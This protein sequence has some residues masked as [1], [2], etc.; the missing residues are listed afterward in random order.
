MVIRKK[1]TSRKILNMETSELFK[2]MNLARQ[3]GSLM[4]VQMARE[5]NR[6][7]WQKV[8]NQDGGKWQKFGGDNNG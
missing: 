8:Y 2:R 1:Y 7:G 3:R 6:R 4:W 5:L